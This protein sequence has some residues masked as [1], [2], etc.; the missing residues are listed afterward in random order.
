LFRR[1]SLTVGLD[2]KAVLHAGWVRRRDAGPIVADTATLGP[3]T[4]EFGWY[5]DPRP[6]PSSFAKVRTQS[7]AI[8]CLTI[9]IGQVVCFEE[10]AAM[11]AARDARKARIFGTIMR[12]PR[13]R[14][15]IR[16][17][18]IMIAAMAIGLSLY[19]DLVDVFSRDGPYNAISQVVKSWDC[20]P[21]SSV[22]VAVDVAEG[23]IRVSPSKDGR[24]TAEIMAVSLTEREDTHWECAGG[25]AR[26]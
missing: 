21:A 11:E 3:A 10:I 15:T 22:A 23:S 25:D 19:P 4:A 26:G 8:C 24:I 7:K 2:G 17:S 13:L 12:L 20:E 18:M 16:G 9:S 1:V 14:F 5:S 6:T